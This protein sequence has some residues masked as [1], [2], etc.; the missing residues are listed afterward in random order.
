MFFNQA[1]AYRITQ[2][3]D[4]S[5]DKLEAAL[6]QKQSQEP[7]SQVLSTCGFMPPVGKGPDAPLVFSAD[8]YHLICFRM[9]ERILPGSVVRDELKAKVEEIE[10]AQQRKVYKKEKDQ[11]KDEIIQTLMP[12]A[13]LRRSTTYA[14][15]SPADGIIFVN[16][17]S[18][19]KA[20]DLLSTLRECIGSLP[21]RPVT[22]KIAPSAS[23]TD[24]VRTGQSPAGFTVLTDARLQDTGEDGG[25]I[26]ATNQ[27]LTHENIQNHISSGMVVHELSLAYEDKLKLVIDDRLKIKKLRFEDILQEQANQDGGDD[28]EGQFAASLVLM[29]KTLL[30]AFPALLTALGGEEVPQGI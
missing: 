4:L 3:I 5:A 17:A 12:R 21:V 28:A 6:Q 22:T 27:D 11:L 29:M 30:Q 20:E 18:P 25:A 16:K 23:M 10:T 15:I 24:W 19:Q 13:F 1:I 26:R 14:A 7:D 9:I 8:G 2:Q